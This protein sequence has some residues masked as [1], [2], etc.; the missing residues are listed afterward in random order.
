MVLDLCDLG[1][2]LIKRSLDF[3]VRR[4]RKQNR[5]RKGPGRRGYSP[6]RFRTKDAV[7]TPSKGKVPR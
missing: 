1:K 6:A 3:P 2:K 4:N 7:M 5:S